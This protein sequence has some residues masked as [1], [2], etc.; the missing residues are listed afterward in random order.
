MA[1][2]RRTGGWR[3]VVLGAFCAAW[4]CAAYFMADELLWRSM[5]SLDDDGLLGMAEIVDVDIVE[6]EVA[7]ME[8]EEVGGDWRDGF[9]LEAAEEDLKRR[10]CPVGSTVR[11]YF[12]HVNKAGGRTLEETFRAPRVDMPTS[13][14]PRASTHNF[15]MRMRTHVTYPALAME[16]ACYDGAGPSLS[17]EKTKPHNCVRWV[18][19]LR[20][21]TSRTLSA[22]YTSTGR[23]QD[24]AYVL[25][26]SNPVLGGSGAQ[27]AH[28]YCDPTSSTARLM[29]AVA[30]TFE[31]FAELPERQRQRDC[32]W[33]ANMH[34]KYLAPDEAD[35]SR[36]QLEA[37][38][39]RLRA[40]AWFFI[41]E[42]PEAS[43]NL[44][45][46][47]LG[48]DFEHYVTMANHNPY[49]HNVSALA[50]DVLLEMNKLD[51]ELY[52]FA[53]ELFD[54]R[55]EEMRADT[56]D[57]FSTALG[58][59]CDAERICWKKGRSRVV[60]WAA[61]E[62]PPRGTFS[63]PGHR[64]QFMLCAPKRGCWRAD[65]ADDRLPASVPA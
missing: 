15:S 46:Y 44:F 41:V 33:A 4:L 39:R 3:R 59:R 6:L 10:R 16:H 45:S 13:H 9:G 36:E 53:V 19:S 61:T 65:L 8:M 28:F 63:S 51:V 21:P 22:F 17:C 5:S 1:R 43:L 12:P 56:T 62:E 25:N 26:E 29:E 18:F 48:V 42:R 31:G 35:G 60:T 37:A 64:K 27:E 49:D 54:T 57:R 30:F 32:R 14:A 40:M 55:L 23:K 52:K 47:A 38:K 50:R 11:L 34:V 20:E 24:R 7:E 58:Y 2:A